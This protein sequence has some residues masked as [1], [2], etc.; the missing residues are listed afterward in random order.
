MGRTGVAC[1]LA[2]LALQGCGSR[3]SA[4]Q[5]CIQAQ[6]ADVLHAL[7]HAPGRVA[8]ADGTPLSQCVRRT[9]DDVRLQ[10]LGAALTAAADALAERM[11]A[12]EAAAFQ[13]GFLI[14]ATA[15]GAAQAA[16]L[17]DELAR[18]VAGSAGLDGGPRRATLLRGRAAGLRAG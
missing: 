4:P 7:A 5:A 14:G 1:L 2:L 3:S 9:I 17:Q 10:A 8:L 12:S 6:T 13:L 16:G 18:R 11:R 15:R